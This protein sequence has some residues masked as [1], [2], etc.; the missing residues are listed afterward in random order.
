[1]LF[2][3]YGLTC[4]SLLHKPFLPPII[5]NITSIALH[6]SNMNSVKTQRIPQFMS[7]L[8]KAHIYRTMWGQS[9]KS[10]AAWLHHIRTESIKAPGCLDF[11]KRYHLNALEASTRPT[12]NTHFSKHRIFFVPLT[13][14]I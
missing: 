13:H 14:V 5:H 10:M 12:K 2:V 6:T 7:F 4:T 3:T 11:L 9:E 8:I 1:M